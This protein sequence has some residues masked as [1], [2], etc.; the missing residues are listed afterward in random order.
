MKMSHTDFWLFQE[1][2]QNMFFQDFSGYTLP[3]FK[4]KVSMAFYYQMPL[5]GGLKM[6]L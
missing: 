3:I 2:V 5:I 1:T 4:S 6:D